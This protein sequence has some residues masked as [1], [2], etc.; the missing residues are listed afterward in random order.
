MDDLPESGFFRAS[1]YNRC[2][3][4]G[5]SW[6]QGARESESE[7]ATG[8]L[9]MYA[10]VPVSGRLDSRTARLFDPVHGAIGGLEEL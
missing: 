7:W 2:D 4:R 6:V 5:F 9:W 1:M 3:D 8:T 10:L